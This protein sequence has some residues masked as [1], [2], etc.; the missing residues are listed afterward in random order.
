MLFLGIFFVVMAFVIS[1]LL[2][3]QK[4]FKVL[5]AGKIL[6]ALIIGT[7]LLIITL[8]S[9]KYMIFKEYDV[10]KGNCSIELSSSGRNAEA[11]I[12]IHE[13]DEWFAFSDIPDLDAYGKSIPYY[14][15]VTLTKDHEFSIGYKIFDLS[16][17][18]L[19]TK[20]E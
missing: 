16:S 19:I 8:P 2:Y 15:E 12:R 14:C 6:I 1:I 4:E 20:N 18:E 7:F 17:R 3:K 5:D 10:V 9:L 11:E 13:T